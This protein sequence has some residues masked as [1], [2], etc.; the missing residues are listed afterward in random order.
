MMDPETHAF[1][2]WLGEEFERLETLE[3]HLAELV[4]GRPTS[5]ALHAIAADIAV[6][7]LS[8]ELEEKEAQEEQRKRGAQIIELC[9]RRRH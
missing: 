2:D 6:L 3:N 1:I 5:Q 4:G 8:R 7:A 9:D